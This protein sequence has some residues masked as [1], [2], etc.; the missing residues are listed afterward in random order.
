[1]I[2]P[3][4]SVRDVDASV[5][6]YTRQLGFIHDFSLP[7]SDGTTAFARV[8]LGSVRLGLSRIE[9]E[10]FDPSAVGFMI[11]IPED[12]DLEQYYQE[13]Q[14]RGTGIAEPLQER[15][16]GDLNF[17]V[18]DPDGYVLALS[19]AVRHVALEDLQTAAR[20]DLLLG[21]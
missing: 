7:R 11:Y 19:K 6:F 16:W 14:H 21:T 18:H 4:L 20:N 2:M 12:A 3:T 13:V 5:A 1:M 9:K 10:A 8:S 17:V 15:Y